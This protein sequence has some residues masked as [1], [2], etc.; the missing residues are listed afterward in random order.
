MTAPHMSCMTQPVRSGV[1]FDVEELWTSRESR[2][3][4]RK[5]RRK[6][7]ERPGEQTGSISKCSGTKQ[8][9]PAARRLEKPW[10]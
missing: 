2:G 1:A 7:A 4:G 6:H 10:L 5:C 9:D 8:I 3:K